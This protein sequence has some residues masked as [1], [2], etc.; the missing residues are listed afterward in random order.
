MGVSLPRFKSIHT[1]VTARVSLLSNDWLKFSSY[2]EQLLGLSIGLLSTVRH[3]VSYNLSWRTLTDPSQLASKYIRRQL[4][5]SLLSALRYTYT[6]DQRDSSIRPT[7][8]YAF[9][10]TSQVGGLWDNKGLKFF[11]QVP[12]EP[13]SVSYCEQSL[14]FLFLYSFLMNVTYH[15]VQ[16]FSVLS[17]YT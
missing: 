13:T 14:S 1:P 3:D 15:L 16:L 9:V 11:R 17:L 5:H 6:M 12:S 8:G 10:S 4:G 7:K 2:K